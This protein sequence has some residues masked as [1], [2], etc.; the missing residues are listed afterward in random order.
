MEDNLNY[1]LIG[2]RIKERRIK[3]NLTQE[4]IAEKIGAST[5]YISK[6]ETSETKMSLNC[7][8]AIANA[9]ETTT[10][11]LLMD[12][13]IASTPQLIGELGTILDD[14]TSEEIY[15]VTELAK[16]LKKGIRN[17]NLKPAE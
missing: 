3:A 1:E 8:V 9:L 13:V 11:H 15:L 16:T 10:D 7:L 6:I 5:R 17:K 2:I 12:N 4:K 14:C